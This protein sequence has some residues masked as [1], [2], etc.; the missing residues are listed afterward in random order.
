M[1]WTP[2]AEA[3]EFY[4][5][6]GPS[7]ST[8]HPTFQSFGELHV[9][10]LGFIG[11]CLACHITTPGATPVPTHEDPPVD[12]YVGCVGCHGREPTPS[13][14]VDW[15]AGLREHHTISG[16]GE[17]AGCHPNDP[18]PIP[19]DVPPLYY[20]DSTI[21]TQTDTCA[22]NLDNDGDDLYDGDDPDCQPGCTSNADCDDGVFC[23]GTETCNTSTNECQAGTPPDCNDG[24]GCTDDSCD[25]TADACVNDPNDA[26]CPDDGTF[27]N[28]TEFCD[29]AA[30][31]SSTG[32][33]CPPGEICDEDQD[34][35]DV[36]GCTTDADCDDGFFCNGTETCNTSTNECQAG[37]PPECDDGVGC[38]V[39]SCNEGTDSC[40]NEPDN[41]SCDNGIFCDGVEFCDPVVDC[42]PGT[43]PDC[44]D[45]VGC[46]DDSCNTTTDACDNDPNDAN[47]PDDDIFCNGTEYCDPAA[48]CSSTGD[49]CLPEESCN[50]DLGICE[51]V[52]GP[53]EVEIE[54]PGSINATNNGKTPIHIE[55]PDSNGDTQ[56]EI[57]ELYCGGDVSDAMAMP[58]RI[59]VEDD[60]ENE[61]VALFNTRDL[62]LVCEDTMMICAGSL[63]DGT[64]FMGMDDL[65]VVRDADGRCGRSWNGRALKLAYE[66]PAI[67]SPHRA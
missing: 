6:G 9:R 8:C 32:D 50:E 11:E 54:V 3:Y 66:A 23:N 7:C 62:M 28:G 42:Q 45:G 13:T 57:V 52:G 65:R 56:V 40:D 43:P 24:V 55:F 53:I 64:L 22:D 37:T 41:S 46:T 16:I 19:E 29:P 15:A 61:F 14:G 49:P 5:N 51:V 21:T 38:T 2:P 47:C 12:G 39:D 63:A 1:V 26:N 58:W 18:E 30:D 36:V 48:D 34:T 31:C 35:C 44:D 60:E 25:T 17:C 4:L 59:N 33:P 20:G 27:C 67:G 10:H